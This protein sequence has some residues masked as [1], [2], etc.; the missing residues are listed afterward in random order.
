MRN[1]GCRYSG[2]S[3]ALFTP[4][5]LLRGS[6]VDRDPTERPG[7]GGGGGGGL[8]LPPAKDSHHQNDSALRW[9]AMRDILILD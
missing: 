7:R 6:G 5:Y 2:C 1:E 3:P 9:E 4:N 8:Y